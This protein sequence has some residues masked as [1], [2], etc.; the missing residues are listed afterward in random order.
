MATIED[1]VVIITIEVEEVAYS[2]MV[3][4]HAETG[5]VDYIILSLCTPVFVCPYL[6]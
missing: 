5:L 6:S 3:E 2:T 4:P 1:V